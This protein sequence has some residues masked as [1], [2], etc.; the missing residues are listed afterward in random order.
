MPCRDLV[1]WARLP[2]ALWNG[3]EW[4][5]EVAVYTGSATID[6]DTGTPFLVYPGKCVIAAQT[7]RKRAT[8]TIAGAQIRIALQGSPSRLPC[9]GT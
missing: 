6:S 9:R 5:D 1:R 7:V 3:P 4:H 8:L 2:V